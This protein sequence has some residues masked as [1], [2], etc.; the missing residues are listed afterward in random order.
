MLCLCVIFTVAGCGSKDE[1]TKG[2]VEISVLARGG[3]DKG[4]IQKFID[5]FNKNNKHNIVIKY[6]EK[7]DSISEYIRV[8][9]QAG[10]A[11]D[12]IEGMSESTMDMALK[13]NWLRA[14][15]DD[16]VN[17]YKDELAEGA[18]TK[19]ADGKYYTVGM[20]QGG[21]CRLIYN[22]EMFA[23]SGLDPENPPKTWDEVREYA[24]ILTKNGGGKKYGFALPFKN[25]GF[26]RWYVMIAGAP[27]DMYN[28]DGFDNATGKFDF[29]IY[30]DMINMYKGIINDGSTFPSPTT[31][32]NDTARAQFAAGNVGMM[33]GM[34]WDVGV[35]NNQFP[36]QMDWGLANIPTFTGEITGSYPGGTGSTGGRYMT[37]NSKHP[38]EQ[39][40]V[41]EYMHSKEYAKAMQDA[42]V[43]VSTYK[44]IGNLDKL[45]SDLK[46]YKELYLPDEGLRIHHIDTPKKPNPAIQGDNYEKAFTAMVMG[47]LD[48]KK[49]LK[50]LTD[51]YNEGLKEWEKKGNKIEDYIIKDWDPNTYVPE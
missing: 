42:G 24:K 21:T 39:L 44:D 50:D 26:G 43:I 32:D 36:C 31:L 6:E 12:I 46:G 29:T 10:T 38:K 45:E 18:V 5:D 47:Q 23:E 17:K 8:A 16:M 28:N 3:A 14:L 13:K 40:I 37:A 1:S 41:W 20:V 15:D 2:K 33:L 25:E 22:K 34:R 11:P 30:E 4:A 19:A 7:D 35:F 27:S 48:V 49:G 9:L 51:R